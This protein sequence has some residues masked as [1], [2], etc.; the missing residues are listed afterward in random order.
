LKNFLDILKRNNSGLGFNSNSNQ[1]NEKLLIFGI[2]E[3]IENETTFDCDAYI[4][5]KIPVKTSNYTGKFVSKEDQINQLNKADFIVINK[6]S[7]VDFN[8]FNYDNAIGLIIREKINEERQN[9][10]ESFD[11]DF[12]I[13]DINIDSYNLEEIFKIKDT[14]SNIHCNWILSINSKNFDQNK[15][16]YI[17]DIGFAGIL[18]DLS[19]MTNKLFKNIKTEIIKIEDK[20]N[21]KL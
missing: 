9:T 5:N 19:N 3:N 1:P 7:D 17:Y 2:A 16:Q 10:L 15:L 21:D 13:Y 18:I 4:Y 11:F 20:K 14:I 8:V 12:L 6:T